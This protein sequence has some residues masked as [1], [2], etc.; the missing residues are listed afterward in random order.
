MISSCSVVQEFTYVYPTGFVPALASSFTVPWLLPPMVEGKQVMMPASSPS[1]LSLD[2]FLG[3]PTHHHPSWAGQGPLVATPLPSWCLVSS[4][5]CFWQATST[6]SQN[7]LPRWFAESNPEIRI[8]P[9]NKSA[10]KKCR[11]LRQTWLQ[12]FS[13]FCVWHCIFFPKM[14]LP[15]PCGGG[16]RD[17]CQ[18]HTRM[19]A[20][21]AHLGRHIPDHP[22][23]PLPEAVGR[24]KSCRRWVL[25]PCVEREKTVNY[26]DC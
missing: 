26:K 22:G 13:L 24:A 11:C 8:F 9:C 15:L 19:W 4:Y 7:S 18:W 6:K 3:L 14:F 17:S 12:P 10:D 20:E 1:S 21:V 23:M 16:E 5:K 2:G 25:E